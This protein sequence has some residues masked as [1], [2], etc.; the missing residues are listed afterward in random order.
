MA[1]IMV[2]SVWLSRGDIAM[3]GSD[4]DLQASWTSVLVIWLS[5]ARLTWDLF[6]IFRLVFPVI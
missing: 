6:E 5:H 2:Q 4:L 1:A 3:V